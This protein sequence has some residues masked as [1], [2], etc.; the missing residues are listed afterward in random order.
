MTNEWLAMTRQCLED[1]GLLKGHFIRIIIY[2]NCIA[3]EFCMY[4]LVKINKKECCCWLH[5]SKTIFLFI[6]SFQRRDAWCRSLNWTIS[7]GRQISFR[8]AQRSR[9]SNSTSRGSWRMMSR[10]N[11]LFEHCSF[12]WVLLGHLP[13]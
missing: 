13:N 9:S 7:R 4:V 10:G 6:F 3:E 2:I 1:L 8:P 5:F 11:R 12:L